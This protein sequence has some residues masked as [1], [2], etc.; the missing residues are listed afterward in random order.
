MFRISAETCCRFT[1]AEILIMAAVNVE[2]SG[3][4]RSRYLN[5]AAKIGC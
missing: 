1:L 4:I 5:G 3:W 2:T